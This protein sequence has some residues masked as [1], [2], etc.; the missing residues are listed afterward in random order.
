MLTTRQFGFRPKTS[1]TVALANFKDTILKKTEAGEVTGAT[2]FDLS[3]AFDAVDPSILLSK[4]KSVSL[5][6]NAVDWF[7]SYLSNRYQ[8]TTIGSTFSDK[9]PIFIAVHQG[10]FVG[11]LLS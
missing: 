5:S 10:S 8:V 6:D 1:T 4:L 3:K 2:F 9:Q 7:H 11:P